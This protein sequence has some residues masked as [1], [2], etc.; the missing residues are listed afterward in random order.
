MAKLLCSENYCSPLLSLQT[1]QAGIRPEK[2]LGVGPQLKE[3]KMDG[4]LTRREFLKASGGASLALLLS[5]CSF[6]VGQNK[7][8]SGSGV[9]VWEIST[10][11]ERE[12]ILNKLKEYNSS[13]PD[14][15]VEMQFFEN[16]PFKQKLRV[17]MG[18]GNPPDIFYGWGG[19][20]LKSYVDAGKVYDITSELEKD[21]RWGDKFFPLVMDGVTFNGKV[22]G[23]PI[24]GM[25]PNVVFYNKTM[26]EK[27]GVAPA[28]T[29]DEL[30]SSIR[31][32]RQNGVIPFALGGESKWTYMIW[33][34]ELTNRIG[35]PE[36]FEA[37]L[38]REPGAWSDPAFIEAG[39][40]FQELISMKA[41]EDGFAGV[42]YDTGQ[43]STLLN[44]GKAAMH[45]IGVY[46]F[47]NHLNAS[48]EFVENDLGWFKVPEVAGASGSFEN[49]SGNLSNFYS[50]TT[51]SGD[52]EAAV[53]FLK[54][55]T[56]D[57]AQRV[58]LGEVPPVNGIEDLL[59][60]AENGDFLTFTY[61]LVKQAT[62]YQL[63]WDQAASPALAEALLTNL[64]QLALMKATPE[65]FSKNMNEAM[66]EA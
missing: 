49:V 8:A 53:T 14:A 7:A 54:E 10:G 12:A 40:Q 41:F 38:R 45:L 6:G 39:T 18:A 29:F 11:L 9:T 22:Y 15:K 16:D 65:E 2:P 23:V 56:L 5:G 28:S 51:T 1:G 37:V 59:R 35:G 58:K 33:V 36:P 42:S 24:S 26:F 3:E 17:A 66:K 31:I 27:Y 30:Q 20:I 25:Q 4:R 47:E 34:Q 52:K 63:S 60:G 62:S 32:L 55:G 46:D 19:G 48:P 50:I 64:D 43:A 13:H 44:T 61:D 21:P 57:P